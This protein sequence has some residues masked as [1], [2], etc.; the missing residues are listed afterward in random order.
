LF[1][2]D[3]KPSAEAQERP[4]GSPVTRSG[5]YASPSQYAWEALTVEPYT[6][7][8]DLDSSGSAEAALA[9]AFE[10]HAWAADGQGVAQYVRGGS[11]RQAA[12]V[13]D[14]LTAA[15]IGNVFLVNEARATADESG[16]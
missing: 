8:V 3:G 13:A 11:P 2:P 6:V 4:P 9:K 5:L 7:L 10:D 14:A 15:G 12:A 16:P 1:E